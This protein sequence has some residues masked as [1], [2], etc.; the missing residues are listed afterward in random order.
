M[1]DDSFPPLFSSVSSVLKK[2]G[3]MDRDNRSRNEPRFRQSHRVNRTTVPGPPVVH[4]ARECG[5]WSGGNP[6]LS[7]ID[8]VGSIGGFVLISSF[9]LARYIR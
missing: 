3:K 4:L 7:V 6:L 8:D 5:R 1:V 9:R 2:Q